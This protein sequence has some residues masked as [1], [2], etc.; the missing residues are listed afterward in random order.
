MNNVTAAFSSKQ[1]G[2]F[3]GGINA[4]P[5]LADQRARGV[6]RAKEQAAF[7]QVTT[8]P[9]LVFADAST[10]ALVFLCVC[11]ILHQFDIS[12]ER[13]KH[14]DGKME[15][16]LGILGTAFA[17]D[18]TKDCAKEAPSGCEECKPPSENKSPYEIEEE[19]PVADEETG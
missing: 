10:F 19:Q 3:V 5:P 18:K 4:V 1:T 9:L 2:R 12:P 8:L 13:I 11:L 7:F 15:Q 16:E 17:S 6:G 14:V